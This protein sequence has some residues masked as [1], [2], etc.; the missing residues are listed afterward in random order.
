MVSQSPEGGVVVGGLVVVADEDEYP[1]F[2]FDPPEVDQGVS[3]LLH[4]AVVAGL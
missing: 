1:L 3:V 2:S 4:G